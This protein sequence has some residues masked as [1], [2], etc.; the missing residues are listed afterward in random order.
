[1]PFDAG[2]E[3]GR[4]LVEVGDEVLVK[5][6]STFVWRHQ[7]EVVGA[8]QLSVIGHEPSVCTRTEDGTPWF[9]DR[10]DYR[11]HERGHPRSSLLDPYNCTDEADG[12]A[13]AGPF[14]GQTTRS[15]DGRPRPGRPSQ[16]MDI[17]EGTEQIQQLVIARAL[18]G[19][20]IE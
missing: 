1:M 14:H 11:S 18:S 17:F 5:G 19:M 8:D 4:H 9:P 15:A 13:H 10:E 3:L 12:I 2:A 7:V 6:S 16:I 20:R